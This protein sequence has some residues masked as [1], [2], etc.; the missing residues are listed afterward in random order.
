MA[1]SVL[2][3][4]SF[5]R[6]SACRLTMHSSACHEAPAIRSRALSRNTRR[7]SFAL[8]DA[9]QHNAPLYPGAREAVGTAGAARGHRSR[10]RHRQIAPR[11]DGCIGNNT[12]SSTPSPRSRHRTTRRRSRS[13]GWCYRRWPRPASIAG[14]YGGYRRYGIRYRDGARRRR[15]LVWRCVGLSSAS[16]LR[17]RGVTAVIDD[18]DAL[19]PAL[20]KL[21][22]E[23]K[24]TDEVASVTS[25]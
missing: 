2:R 25:V 1:W 11:R 20:G 23:L 13:L 4:R 15:V 24:I 8:R 12:G 16:D 17:A 10:S 14:A 3:E 22:P 6:L 18:F 7:P 9:G 19:A 21:W 5:C